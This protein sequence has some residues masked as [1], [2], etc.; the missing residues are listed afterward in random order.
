MMVVSDGLLL[1]VPF[2]SLCLLLQ[3]ILCAVQR[4]TYWSCMKACAS[5]LQTPFFKLAQQFATSQKPM[6]ASGETSFPRV[7]LAVWVQNKL[8]E[9]LGATKTL[10][11]V[12]I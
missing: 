5:R 6:H 3:V 4:E 2:A 10:V 12:N 11:E 9:H 7:F 8:Q 1:H